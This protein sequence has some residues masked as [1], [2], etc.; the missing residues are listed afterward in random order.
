MDKIDIVISRLD[1]MKDSHN[2]RL[3]SIDANL[4][5]HMRRTDLIELKNEETEK[6]VDVLEQP[7]EA[8]K[9]IL[10]VAKWIAGIAGSILIVAKLLDKL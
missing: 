4:A 3:E 8:R 10:G 9:Y 2:K 1:D 6:R 5:E 7:S